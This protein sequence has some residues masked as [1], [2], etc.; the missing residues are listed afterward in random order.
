MLTEIDSKTGNAVGAAG[1]A[2]AG[3]LPGEGGEGGGGGG[4]NGTSGGGGDMPVV[5][6]YPLVE[7]EPAPEAARRRLLSMPKPGYNMKRRLQSLEGY[8]LVH[9]PDGATAGEVFKA[10]TPSG[11]VWAFK[12]PEELPADRIIKLHL[13]DLKASKAGAT[14]KLPKRVFLHG[15][16][17]IKKGKMLEEEPAGEEEAAAAVEE[18]V[19]SGNTTVG[20][21]FETC[22]A[23]VCALDAPGWCGG[24]QLFDVPMRCV[25][26]FCYFFA[27]WGSS[28]R[29]QCEDGSV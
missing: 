27:A 14:L 23:A 13:P 22:C 9:V 24:N 2:V 17:L 16:P 6:A 28:G 10:T 11:V 18:G 19:P 20:T 4:G 5:E 8:M 3:A 12:V 29:G 1:N 26:F 25:F 15:K 7:A 21:P